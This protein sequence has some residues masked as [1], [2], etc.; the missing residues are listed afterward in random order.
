MNAAEVARLKT[1]VEKL[2]ECQATFA[3]DH[4]IIETHKGAIVWEG[5]IAEFAIEGNSQADTCYAWVI[6]LPDG[7][8]QDTAVLK[9]SNA[10]SPVNA[11]RVYLLQRLRDIPGIE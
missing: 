4:Y 1:A 2:H 11:L 8:R 6:Q 5:W 10:T 7:S 3:D 9:A